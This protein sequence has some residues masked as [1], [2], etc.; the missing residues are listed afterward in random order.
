MKSQR[1][2]WLG[3]VEKMSEEQM[4]KSMFK[5]RLLSKRRKKRPRT[6]WMDNV[7]MGVRGWRGRVEDRGGWRRVV[8][9][10]K[11]HQELQICDDER[12][13]DTCSTYERK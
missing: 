2:R 11:A 4:T 7:L 8:K 3:H 1:I 9:E 5:K 6:R 12:N 10:V 13:V